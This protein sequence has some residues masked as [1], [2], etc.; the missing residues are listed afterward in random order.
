[1]KTLSAKAA[2]RL[3]KEKGQWYT[4]V[5]KPVQATQLEEDFTWTSGTG[6]SLKGVRGDWLIKDG[7][8]V[9]TVAQSTFTTTHQEVSPG[10]Y[11]KVSPALLLLLDCD[12]TV[13]SLEGPSSGAKGDILAGG[14][15]GNVWIMSADK[16]NRYTLAK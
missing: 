10:W 7:F 8:E 16:W 5:S 2:L 9:W 11:K 13:E 12:L 14:E 15:S 4:P 3:L 6:S 1:M